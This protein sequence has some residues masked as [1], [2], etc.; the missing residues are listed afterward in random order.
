MRLKQDELVRGNLLSMTE[1]YTESSS[2]LQPSD[3]IQLFKNMCKIFKL[4]RLRV[5][6]ELYGVV[7]VTKEVMNNAICDDVDASFTMGH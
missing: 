2:V 6:R 1:S 4:D 7:E 3:A 5:R